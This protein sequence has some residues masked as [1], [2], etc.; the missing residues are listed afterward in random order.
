VQ[1]TEAIW[2]DSAAFAETDIYSLDQRSLPL[3][4]ALA[5]DCMRARYTEYEWSRVREPEDRRIESCF[6]IDATTYCC[7]VRYAA[8]RQ[9]HFCP[10]LVILSCKPLRRYA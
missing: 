7:R 9:L 5:E 10:P 6:V 3:V 2:S 1:V 4:A 8:N